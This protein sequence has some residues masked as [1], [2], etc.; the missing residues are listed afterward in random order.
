[1][2]KAI[3]ALEDGT[4]LEGKGFGFPCEVS[5]E[6]VFNT[7]M[8]GYPEA[9]TD[10]SY[11]GQI[12]VQTYIL[13]GCYGIPSFSLKE[14]GIPLHFESEGI[15]VRGYV[16][17]ELQR[18]PSHWACEKSLDQWL[19]EQKIPGIEG[20]DTRE[21]TKKLRI[22]GVMLAILKVGDYDLE[23]IREKLEK[24]E[25]PNKKNLVK[26][27]SIPEPIEYNSGKR[28]IV[29]IDCGTKYGI[30]RSL[31]SRKLSVIRV[32]FDF[33][34]DKIL[35]FE[36]DGIVISNG[37]G[38]PKMCEE[39]IKTVKELL[40]TNL[41]M[42]GICLGNQILALASGANTY[43]LKFGHRG[44]NHPVIDLKTR[45]CYITSQNHGYAVEI[46]SLK[47]TYFEPWFINANDKTIEGIRHNKK[48]IFGVQFHPEASPGPNDTEFLFDLFLKEVERC[49]G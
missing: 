43:K 33:S 46:N 23:E 17:S 28:K 9:L 10:P 22:K 20:I 7:G 25:D 15:K 47:E 48:P 13:I 49:Q 45:K 42:M 34:C 19:Y 41:P 5:G 11:F 21:L 35:A 24:I 44:Q 8:V 39:T 4:L 3:L 2:L 27:V 31:I 26:E 32:P 38:D 29:L 18:K 14:N 1:M 30:L 12:L 40:E 16:I 36:P 6:V 37:P